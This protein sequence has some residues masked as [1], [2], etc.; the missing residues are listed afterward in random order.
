MKLGVA[1]LGGIPFPVRT[2]LEDLEVQIQAGWGVQHKGD[3]SHGTVIADSLNSPSGVLPIDTGLRLNAGPILVDP[4]GNSTHAAGIRPPT[5]TA[6]QN[7]YAPIGIDT[8]I[9]MEVDSS[10][11]VAITGI[12]VAAR[13]KRWL[14]V[15]NRGSKTITLKDNVTSTARYRF[16]FNGMD[17]V[18]G[19]SEGAMLVY[20]V[21]SEIWRSY[22][23]QFI[24]A[25]SV[26]RANN[27]T[28]A[29]ST[30][31]KVTLDTVEYDVQSHFDQVTNYRWTCPAPGYYEVTAR[32]MI[33]SPS[34]LVGVSIY[35]NGSAYRDSYAT[36]TS[37][38]TA[39]LT[40]RP[41]LVETD[42]LEMWV[43]QAN[44]A[45]RT[46]T[47]GTRYNSFDVKR[48]GA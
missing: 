33:D 28:I 47:G 24:D 37:Y 35:K 31:T 25:V 46:L 6:D 30:W 2:A 40:A 4:L 8:A 21:G 41:K 15:L 7:D 9:Q 11:D 32:V 16:S 26:Y 22:G 27:Q 36:G 17:L 43:F 10:T 1:D 48:V 20:D 14:Y 5:L 34:A 12:Q 19:S 23:L 38:C 39:T 3:G 44:A 18:L 42:Y 29:A 45:G 13:Q